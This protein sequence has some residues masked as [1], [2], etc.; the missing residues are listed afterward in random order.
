M[1]RNIK[2]KKLAS[3]ALLL[4]ATLFSGSVFQACEK[5]ESDSGMPVVN[6]IRITDPVKSDFF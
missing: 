2:I 1:K 4:L 6:Y 5:N 3:M